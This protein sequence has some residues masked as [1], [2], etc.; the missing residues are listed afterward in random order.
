MLQYNL[1]HNEVQQLITNGDFSAGATGWIIPNGVTVASGKATWDGYEQQAGIAQGAMIKGK[2]YAVQFTISGYVAGAVSIFDSVA[3]IGALSYIANQTVTETVTATADGYIRIEGISYFEGSVDNVSVIGLAET[4][5]AVTPLYATKKQYR[6]ASGQKFMRASRVGEYT[7]LAAD[8]DLINGAPFETRFKL[9]VYKFNGTVYALDWTGYFYKIDCAFDP[10]N[11]RLTVECSPEDEYEAVLAGMDKQF[12]LIDLEPEFAPVKYTRRPVFQFYVE[13]SAKVAN[14]TG[15]KYWEDDAQTIPTATEPHVNGDL[16]TVYHFDACAD[17]YGIGTGDFDG[18]VNQ[19]WKWLGSPT[20]FVSNDGLYRVEAMPFPPKGWQLVEV[21]T[22]DVMATVLLG[23][24]EDWIWDGNWAPASGYTGDLT[25]TRARVFC[26]VITGKTSIAGG[27]ISTLAIPGSDIVASNDNYNRAAP[28]GSCEILFGEDTRTAATKYGIVPA[29]FPN[30]GEYYVQPQAGAFPIVNSI[31]EQY[32]FWYMPG[33][34]ETGIEANDGEQVTL[35]HG[36]Y[37][38]SVIAKLL[39]AIGASVDHSDS[40]NY[41]EWLYGT[42]VIPF[43]RPRMFLTPISNILAGEYDEPDSV[44]NISLS[45]IEELLLNGHR[46]FWHIASG[47]FV[48]EHTSFYDNGWLYPAGYDAEPTFG[49]DLTTRLHPQHLKAW[50][51]KQS[52]RYAKVEMPERI[53]CAWAQSLSVEFNAEPVL[54]DN[55]YSQPGQIEQRNVSGFIADLDY[56]II[57][58]G[59]VNKEGFFLLDCDLVG[60]DFVVPSPEVTV[61]G[62]ALTL[63]NGYLCWWYLLPNFHSYDLPSNTVTMNKAE[64]TFTQNVTRYKESDEMFSLGD[65]EPDPDMQMLMKSGVGVGEVF[66]LDIDDVTNYVTC[67]LRYET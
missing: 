22:S 21:A 26:R 2:Q 39:E 61:N 9:D 19:F 29:G 63:Q 35:Q 11:S 41:S 15:G 27:T 37:L 64:V 6:R 47:K 20:R 49:V 10:Y 54:I 4:T 16:K 62:S 30:T 14:F 59:N 32:G 55:A 7:F 46:G 57:S 24:T 52:Y 65:T 13:G 23:L 28:Y 33:T 36:Y 5:T 51:S 56:A 25:F 42:T 1:R 66:E 17:A 31:W 53:Q 3:Q 18:V 40:H 12:N 44:E 34:T 48:I 67:K 43:R 38:H 58:P 8:F 45:K 50:G 60:T